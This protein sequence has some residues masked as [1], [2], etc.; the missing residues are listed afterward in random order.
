MGLQGRVQLI[1]AAGLHELHIFIFVLAVVHVLYSCLTV[2]LG[3]WQV[4]SWKRW[5]TETR[6]ENHHSVDVGIIQ[7]Q[8]VN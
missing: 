6:E 3:L 7:S 5:E 2:L 4:H 1:S 8:L